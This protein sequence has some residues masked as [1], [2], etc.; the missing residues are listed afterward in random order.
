MILMILAALLM[1][2]VDSTSTSCQS[3]FN[4]CVRSGVSRDICKVQADICKVERRR[5]R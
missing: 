1:G 3:Q 5:G 4:A 2:G